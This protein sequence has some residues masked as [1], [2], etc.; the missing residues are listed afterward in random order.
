VVSEVF[1]EGLATAFNVTPSAA[2]GVLLAQ[3]VDDNG[4]PTPGIPGGQLVVPG[5]V[6]GPFFLDA[7]LAPDPGA[8][9]TSTSGYVVFFEV[10]VGV[11]ELG[12]AAAPTVTLAMPASP[13][14]AGTITLARIVTT[15]GAPEVPVNVSFSNTIRPIFTARGCVACHSGGWFDLGGLKL[16]GPPQQLYGELIEE[17]PTRVNTVDPTISLL[18]R[19]PARE[20]P[21]DTH[22][23]VTFASNSD[24]DYQKILVWIS[25]GALDN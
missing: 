14:N 22:P 1:L 2:K 12:Q 5:G 19:M 15:A 11:V 4:D 24:P 21:A 17:D 18:L 23:N 3:L 10:D 20:D 9:A 6:D 7:D 16:D 8:T 25:E 13:I